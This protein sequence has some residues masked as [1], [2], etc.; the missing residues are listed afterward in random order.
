VDTTLAPV[1]GRPRVTLWLLRA[2]VTVHLVAV[3][4][5]PV[6]AGRYFD[7]DVD[8]IGWHAAL[9]SVVAALGLAVIAAALLY[10]VAARRSW[11]LLVVAALLFVAEGLQIGFGYAHQLGLHVPLGVAVAVAAVLLAAWAWRGAR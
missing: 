9:G 6:L 4:L 11:P 2:V 5:Q 3:L 1:R 7:G 8:A 10:V